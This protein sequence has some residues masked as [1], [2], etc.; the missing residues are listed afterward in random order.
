MSKNGVEKFF[1]TFV[2]HGETNLNLEGVLQGHVNAPLNE[3]GQQQASEIGKHLQNEKYTHIYSSDLD[4]AFHTC[5]IL[6]QKNKHAVSHVTSSNK[7]S[8]VKDLI[9]VDKKLR[10]R[11]FGSMEGKPWHFL[12]KA[13]K[14]AGLD[15]IDFI[16]PGA[17]S[18][19]EVSVRGKEFFI[20][21]CKTLCQD[22]KPNSGNM[23]VCPNVLVVSH[24]G[25]I[26]STIRMF[27]TDFGC[28]LQR[29]ILQSFMVNCAKACFEVTLPSIEENENSFQLDASSS[30]ATTVD[31]CLE[32]ITL[33]CTAYNVTA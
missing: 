18:M 30:S 15:E 19:H 32:G 24:G 5:S 8:D 1:L 9:K 27:H 7:M 3:T 31:R 29:Y 4:R 11:K 6:L 16:P 13:A 2:R 17:E 33:K 28:P 25:Y 12:H 20:D 10:E 26:R 21:L 23:N 22:W 14:A